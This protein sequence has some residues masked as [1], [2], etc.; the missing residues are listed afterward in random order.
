M[1][2][3]I[4]QTVVYEKYHY[5]VYDN[6]HWV[7]L[8]KE[9]LLIVPA[10]IVHIE[11]HRNFYILKRSSLNDILRDHFYWRVI[12]LKEDLRVRKINVYAHLNLDSI[13]FLYGQ[14]YSFPS[15]H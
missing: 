4:I 10:N 5:T 3:S 8:A 9:I 12:V 14:G 11:V 7:R 6:C 1:R 15:G 13:S 2:L